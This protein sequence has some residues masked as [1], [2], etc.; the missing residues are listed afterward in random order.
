[1]KGF[2]SSKDSVRDKSEFESPKLMKFIDESPAHSSYSPDVNK[3]KLNVITE[4]ERNPEIYKFENPL[5]LHK[6]LKD[7][8]EDEED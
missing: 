5:N 3:T 6:M 7:E 8:S 2:I 1:M 4:E